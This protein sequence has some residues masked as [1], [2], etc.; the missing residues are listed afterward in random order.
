MNRRGM[1]SMAMDFD[2][3][4]TQEQ[5]STAASKMPRSTTVTAPSSKLPSPSLV[6]LK[7]SLTR[8][9]VRDSVRPAVSAIRFL[10]SST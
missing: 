1:P 8:V 3:G 2:D 9:A 6:E 7:F 10:P 4:W 5:G